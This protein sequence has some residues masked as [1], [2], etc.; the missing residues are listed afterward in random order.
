MSHKLY[1]DML[2]NVLK[3]MC[4]TVLHCIVYYYYIIVP[5]SH[6]LYTKQSGTFFLFGFFLFLFTKFHISNYG[7]SLHKYMYNLSSKV[8]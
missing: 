2:D 5:I 6:Y 8:S 3:L 4:Y 1:K 7:K